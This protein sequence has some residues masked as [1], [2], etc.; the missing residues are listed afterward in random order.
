MTKSNDPIWLC[1]SCQAV[2]D[3]GPRRQWLHVWRLRASIT[4]AKQR[5]QW[6]QMGAKDRLIVAALA[7]VAVASLAGVAVGVFMLVNA[8]QER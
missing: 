4:F 7:L 1:P 6:R 3:W 2:H 5:E 8:V